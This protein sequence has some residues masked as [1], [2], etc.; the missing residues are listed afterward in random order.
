YR[1]LVGVLLL[2][3]DRD[4]RD[5]PADLRRWAALRVPR[6]AGGPLT[7]SA[8][9]STTKGPR[10]TSVALVRALVGARSRSIGVRP[11]GRRTPFVLTHIVYHRRTCRAGC[12]T[13]SVCATARPACDGSGRR[14]PG[15]GLLGGAG[16]RTGADAVLVE[17]GG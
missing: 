13:R 10:R 12:A 16:R 6:P 8:P 17:I 3:G 15:A 14:R 9:H 7:I 11:G 4:L 2:L 5:H 1:D